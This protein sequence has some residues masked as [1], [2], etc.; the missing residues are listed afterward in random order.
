M[1]DCINDIIENG[2]TERQR[3]IFKNRTDDY[4]TSGEIA[5]SLSISKRTVENHVYMARSR[6][7]NIEE[8]KEVHFK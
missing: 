4:M 7:K 1:S 2:L 3:E 6:L 8:V 5:E